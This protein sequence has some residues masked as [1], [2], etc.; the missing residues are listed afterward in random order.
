M[1]PE[2]AIAIETNACS[3]RVFPDPAPLYLIS[4]KYRRVKLLRSTCLRR[5]NCLGVSAFDTQDR[6]RAAKNGEVV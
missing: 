5:Y 6:Y 2:G 3:L 1:N 4:S